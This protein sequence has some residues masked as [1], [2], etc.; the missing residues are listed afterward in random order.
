M[1]EDVS[2]NLG[3]S[4]ELI[5]S[6]QI[7]YQTGLVTILGVSAIYATINIICIC[8][9]AMC[10]MWVALKYL[11]LREER[12]KIS[13]IVAHRFWKEENQIACLFRVLAK[14]KEATV[15]RDITAYHILSYKYRTDNGVYSLD[16]VENENDGSH[17]YHQAFLEKSLQ[18][19]L[20]VFLILKKIERL[21]FSLILQLPQSKKCSKQVSSTVSSPLLSIA[22]MTSLVWCDEK[23][24]AIFRVVRFFSGPR[25]AV[26]LIRNHVRDNDLETLVLSRIPYVTSLFLG[27]DFSFIL[28][29]PFR[30]T[31]FQKD[32]AIQT[33]LKKIYQIDKFFNENYQRLESVKEKIV[34]FYQEA[35]E[36]SFKNKLIFSRAHFPDLSTIRNGGLAGRFQEC[37]ACLVHLLRLMS[38]GGNVKKMESDENFVP[39]LNNLVELIDTLSSGLSDDLATI[40]RTCSN[41][42]SC[43][44][45]LT[46]EH[47]LTDREFT[48]AKLELIE[49]DLKSHVKYLA[50]KKSELK[51]D[52][53]T[54]T[55]LSLELAKIQKDDEP[56]PGPSGIKKGEIFLP[57]L[58]L[59]EKKSEA[60]V[61]IDV[62]EDS[63]EDPYC[64]TN[65]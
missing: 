16:R 43:L 59:K 63:D 45:G 6:S 5:S 18:K 62:T 61:T 23:A 56:Q 64:E 19:R 8:L 44:N 55:S 33:L 17:L 24:E 38:Y 4:T 37:I 26:D 10:L 51:K 34:S 32:P 48:K 13:E 57:L 22:Q 21:F 25:A 30:D 35:R 31:S 28:R 41:I 47:I 14:M 3:N 2:I 29:D 1:G 12:D 60:S 42:V 53:T 65:V 52:L 7:T 11:R 50:S 9:V 58:P 27:P 15:F 40:E 39:F 49:K 54:E 36:L 46:S 20:N